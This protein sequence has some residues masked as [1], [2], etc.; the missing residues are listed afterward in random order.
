MGFIVDVAFNMDV[1]I[2]RYHVNGVNVY[3]VTNHGLLFQSWTIRNRTR[4]WKEIFTYVNLVT[5]HGFVTV[6]VN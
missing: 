3:V 6:G 2:R 1:C 4:P 5:N